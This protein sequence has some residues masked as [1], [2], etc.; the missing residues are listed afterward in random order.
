LSR[1]APAKGPLFTRSRKLAIDI[2]SD[3]DDDFDV[4]PTSSKKAP[5]RVAKST[6]KG[7]SI[8]EVD[9]VAQVQSAVRSAAEADPESTL[10]I[11]D[12]PHLILPH[13]FVEEGNAGRDGAVGAQ[14]P[15]PHRRTR[16]RHGRFRINV[17]IEKAFVGA[18]RRVFA[19]VRNV[20]VTFRLQAFGAVGSDNFA[21]LAVDDELTIFRGAAVLVQILCEIFVWTSAEPRPFERHTDRNGRMSIAVF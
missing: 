3:S 13:I 14:K 17:V 18:I 12:H 7:D 16:R 6:S 10:L 11:H 2:A 9:H 1:Q 15:D 5:S 8:S 20:E 21:R 19:K 4:R